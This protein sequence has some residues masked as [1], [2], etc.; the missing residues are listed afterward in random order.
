MA[1]RWLTPPQDIAAFVTQANQTQFAAE[2]FHFGRDPRPVT[3]ELR[4]LRAGRYRFVLAPEGTARA[5][6]VGEV[7]IERGRFG[8]L[9]F[10]LPPQALCTLRIEALRTP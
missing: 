10:Q 6:T 8:R 3:A 4:M 7:T 2:L 1:V 9:Q 5:E